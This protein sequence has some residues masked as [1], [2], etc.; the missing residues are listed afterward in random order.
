GG[1]WR[2]EEVRRATEGRLGNQRKLVV[3][4]AGNLDRLTGK[5]RG[6]K[7]CFECRLHSRVAQDSWTSRSICR[8]YFAGLV[9]DHIN[10]NYALGPHALRC[11]GIKRWR[12][13]DCGAIENATRHG[14]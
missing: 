2:A 10:C 3:N 1:E 8:N 4:H 12:Q 11:L 9:K 5:L 7:S 6:R 13:R 14:L